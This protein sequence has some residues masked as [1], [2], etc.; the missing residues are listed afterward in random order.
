MD[1]PLYTTS[2]RTELSDLGS[3]NYHMFDRAIVLDI[4]MRQAGSNPN[5]E[6]F[7]DIL[8]RLR[9][10]ELAQEDWKEFMKQTPAEL[11]D[12][13]SFE[14]ALRLYPT[15]EAVAEHNASKLRANGQPIAVIRAAHTGP[16]ASR[17]SADEAGGLEP[18]VCLAQGARVMLSANIWVEVGLVNGALGSVVSIC[19]AREHCPPD[20]PIAVTVKFDFY[21]GPTLSDGTVPI[22][23]L[24][25][26]WF[27]TAKQCSRLQ[28]P[29]RLAWAVTI[30]KSQG[31]TLDKV[32]IDVG[33][34]EFSSGSTFVACS[35]V[36][37]LSDLLFVPPF[38][39]QRVQNLSKSNRLKERREE[40]ARLNQIMSGKKTTEVVI[41]ETDF[42]SEA[43]L[44]SKV[45]SDPITLSN[46]SALPTSPAHTYE[47]EF[48]SANETAAIPS[49]S[50]NEPVIPSSHVAIVPDSE[51]AATIL[52][53]RKTAEVMIYETVLRP[54]CVYRFYPV[55]EAWRRSVCESL[56]LTYHGENGVAQG[57][58]KMCLKRPLTIQ[59]ISGDGNCFY[60]S[61]CYILT[62]SEDEHLVVRR[63]IVSH[64]I[65]I[66]D[67]LT[68]HL[69]IGVEQYISNNSVE[70]GGVWAT[71]TEMLATSSLLKADIYSYVPNETSTDGT[72][73]RIHPRLMEPSLSEEAVSKRGIYIRNPTNHFEVVLSVATCSNCRRNC[74]TEFPASDSKNPISLD[75]RASPS[76]PEA[77]LD[78][79]VVA[80]PIFLSN[81][82]ALPTS[83]ADTY[84][85]E[86]VSANETAVIPINISNEPPIPSS[87][88]A[89]V[90]DSES[91]ATP[92]ILSNQPT[93]IFQAS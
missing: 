1:L 83:P 91:A 86:F 46:Q 26:T 30:H 78:S 21:T 68:G 45:V 22:C 53:G 81:P 7:R 15:V 54:N 90:P 82:P 60:R 24:Q 75:T 73:L 17:V 27:S 48:V 79:K 65:T 39:Y 40:D 49:A 32:V 23:P 71:E 89:V 58:P 47:L 62:G 64:M 38:P 33:K 92:I 29:L 52:S 18:V 80:G 31:L 66:G 42:R 19:Y 70:N 25:R 36:H 5:Q 3:A 77:I 2:P 34:K 37:R 57:G 69:G 85:L 35:R 61:I 28:L 12:T 55:D 20:L 6:L 9:N 88:V 43:I 76:T 10:G 41:C 8:M 67:N 50:S 87:P 74:E 51:T 59:R 93:K 72:W 16:E 63:A 14:R 13:T 4:V 56:N 44:F 11:G 84:E